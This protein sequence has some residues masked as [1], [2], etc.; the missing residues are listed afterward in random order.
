MVGLVK[1]EEF[2]SIS[3][4]PGC[5]HMDTRPVTFPGGEFTSVTRR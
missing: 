3:V 4:K 5:M 1:P 2:L